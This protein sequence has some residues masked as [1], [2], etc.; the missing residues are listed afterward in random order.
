MQ[1]FLFVNGF[2]KKNKKFFKKI[3][4]RFSLRYYEP[5]TKFIN[6]KIVIYYIKIYKPYKLK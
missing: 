4:Q 1:T 3:S 6:L 5:F 2:F